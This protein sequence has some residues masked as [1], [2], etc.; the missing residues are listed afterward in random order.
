[1]IAGRTPA[2]IVTSDFNGSGKSDLVWRD[3]S[4]ATVAIRLKN[5]LQGAPSRSLSSVPSNRD[6]RPRRNLDADRVSRRHAALSSRA[7]SC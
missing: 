2:I 1:M 5:G 3:N 4:S 6:A 7:V